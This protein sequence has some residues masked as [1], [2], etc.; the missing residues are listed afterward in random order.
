[1]TG[2]TASQT[3]S[4]D[5]QFVTFVQESLKKRKAEEKKRKAE[6]KKMDMVKKKE[7]KAIENER[8]KEIKRK[9]KEEEIE[10]QEQKKL[11]EQEEMERQ[12]EMD[13]QEQK[14]LMEQE[15]MERQQEMD[16]QEQ[17]KVKEQT[18]LQS[19][20]SV[21]T[22]LEEFNGLNGSN[23]VQGHPCV[24]P[25]LKV[26]L[27]PNTSKMYQ[28]IGGICKTVSEK[29][30]KTIGTL[31]DAVEVTVTVVPN[32]TDE[33]FVRLGSVGLKRILSVRSFDE[34]SA[35][36]QS[37]SRAVK[38]ELTEILKELQIGIS[39]SIDA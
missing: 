27:D 9:R 36:I 11:M 21:N 19:P 35:M 16:V 25:A 34:S 7:E 29:V 2:F 28:Y 12:Q 20:R 23:V 33:F 3:N 30:S 18:I 8:I 5:E 13:V 14:K 37:C 17:K 32:A 22:I 24:I 6:E 26:I 15:E 38:G 1:M 4:L 31:V 39:L 10:I